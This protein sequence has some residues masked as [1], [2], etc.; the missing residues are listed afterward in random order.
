MAEPENPTMFEGAMQAADATLIKIEKMLARD[1][2]KWSPEQ[3]ALITAM[4]DS[5][6]HLNLAVYYLTNDAGAK[7]IYRR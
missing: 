1:Q 3:L 5:I 4:Y 7:A 2:R 6:M